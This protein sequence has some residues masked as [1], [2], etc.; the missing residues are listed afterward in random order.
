MLKGLCIFDQ[1]TSQN[2]TI[3]EIFVALLKVVQVH[4]EKVARR[5]IGVLASSKNTSRGH[6]I[7]APPQR[8]QPKRYER[9]PIDYNSLDSIGNY[10]F[11]FIK[12]LLV[13]KFVN[14]CMFLFS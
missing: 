4:K 10:V 12:L 7:I 14:R 13:Y 2:S 8:E 1:K 5:E 6:K 3:V 9:Q 11:A